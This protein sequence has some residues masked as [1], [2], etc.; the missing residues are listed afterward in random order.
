MLMYDHE[1]TV[2]MTVYVRS[3][4]ENALDF[5]VNDVLDTLRETVAQTPVVLDYEIVDTTFGD[6]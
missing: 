6:Y 3:L 5:G 4:Q 1:V 2:T